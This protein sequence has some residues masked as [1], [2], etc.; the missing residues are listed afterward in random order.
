MPFTHSAEIGNNYFLSY[1]WSDTYQKAYYFF[2]FS[3]KIAL[4]VDINQLATSIEP[5]F[6]KN[7]VA[8]KKSLNDIGTSAHINGMKNYLYIL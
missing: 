5:A 4:Q 8:L 7:A 1:D 2:L 6:Q 3:G